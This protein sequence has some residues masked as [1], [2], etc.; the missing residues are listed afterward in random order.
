[1]IQKA[2]T[3]G[4]T[5]V[6]RDN[7]PVVENKALPNPLTGLVPLLVVLVISFVF[8]D[9]LKQSALIIALLGGVV[10]TYL[11][12]RKYFKSFWDAVSD[13]TMGALVAIGNTAAVVGF[14]GVAKA[15]PA[16]QTAV[17]AMTNIPGSPLIGGAIAVSV[18]AGM[19][20]SSSGGQAIA[21]PL[22]APHYLDMGVNAEALHRTIAISSG[23]LDSLPHNGYVVTTIRSI[24]GESHEDAYGAVGALTVIVPA[25]GVVLAI[26]LFSLGLG[27]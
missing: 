26:V 3:K 11:L 17:D 16:F 6:G 12:N 20:G 22:L 23:A 13:G 5:F 2:V 7:D 21:L 10:A 24:C 18:I 4:E 1:M 15:V 8:H 27:I 19:T 9:S 25:I 14:G